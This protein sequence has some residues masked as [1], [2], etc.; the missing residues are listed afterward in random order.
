MNKQGVIQKK[1]N[2]LKCTRE[3]GVSE[4]TIVGSLRLYA[5]GFKPLYR[6]KND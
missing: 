2:I 1:L 5:Q 6:Q 4:M 3:K